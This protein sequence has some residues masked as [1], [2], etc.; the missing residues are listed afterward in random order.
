MDAGAPVLETARLRLRA[1]RR[2]DLSDCAAMWGDERVARFIGGKPATV[3]EAWSKILRYAGLW[4]LLG[5]G[6]WAV[7]E[8]GS[9]RFVGEV[10]FADF[11]RDIT[12]SLGDEPEA[13]WVLAPWAHGVGFATEAVRAMH[14]WSDAHLRTSSTVCIIDPENAR[15]IGLA[16]KCGYR[17]FARSTYKGGPAV[18]FRRGAR[19][20]QR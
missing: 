6:Y 5:F 19:G 3:E 18:L 17:E 8:K 10:G 12:P 1:H 2:D 7:E 15:S 20:A 4:S 13:G 9:G 16:Q 11:R 14:V